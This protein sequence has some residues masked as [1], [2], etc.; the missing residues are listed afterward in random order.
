MSKIVKVWCSWCIGEG[1]HSDPLGE[2]EV[3]DD[4]KGDSH[5]I[6]ARHAEEI[7]AE[8]LRK[9]NKNKNHKEKGD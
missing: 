3:G 2:V 1:I 4:V 5:G 7:W 8:Y 6:C 9:Q